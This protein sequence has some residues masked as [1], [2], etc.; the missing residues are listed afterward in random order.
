MNAVTVVEL[1]IAHCPSV[2]G[3]GTLDNGSQ[4]G[5]S[6]PHQRGPRAQSFHYHPVKH[7]VPQGENPESNPFPFVLRIRKHDV[8]PGTG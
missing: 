6:V 3:Q 7:H 2:S 8:Q 5:R 1:M 4:P